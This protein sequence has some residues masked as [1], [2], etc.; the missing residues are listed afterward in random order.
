V[1]PR[2]DSGKALGPARDEMITLLRRVVESGT[3][4]RAA[5]DGF[6]AGK[7]GTSQDYRDAWFIGFNKPLVAG[8]WVGNDDNRPMKRVVGGGLPAMIWQR[9]MAMATQMIA[10]DQIHIAEPA[11]HP[12]V[13]EGV[14]ARA[15]DDDLHDQSKIDREAEPAISDCDVAACSSAY[16][17]FRA[18]DCTYQPYH[19]PRQLCTRGG[20]SGEE[21][22]TIDTVDST[23]PQPRVRHRGAQPT[24]RGLLRMF[25]VR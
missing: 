15:T 18:S 16:D 8:V 3:G 1:G 13:P 25:R 2:P 21:T 17:S 24:I 23:P 9:F 11:T 20:S 22:E 6:A 19:G 14:Y 5:L 7:T 12:Q 10:E 4:R